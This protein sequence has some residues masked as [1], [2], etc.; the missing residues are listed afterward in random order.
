MLL[1][2]AIHSEI[3]S[4]TAAFGREFPTKLRDMYGFAIRPHHLQR[5]RKYAFIYKEEETERS[6]RWELFLRTYGKENA[7]ESSALSTPEDGV[8]N[9]S[10]DKLDSDNS[11]GQDR[12]SSD[13]SV[14]IEH[15][16]GADKLLHVKIREIQI[17]GELRP[18]LKTLGQNFGKF[19]KRR[20]KRDSFAIDSSQDQAP[21]LDSPFPT[22]ASITATHAFTN[23][24]A[25]VQVNKDLLQEVGISDPDVSAA[26]E[27]NLKC[28]SR[29][30][31]V[32]ERAGARTEGN[33]ENGSNEGVNNFV[34]KQEDI[35]E[36]EEL[37]LLVRGGV[38][39]ALRGELWQVFVG[40]QAR[41]VEGHYN[42]LLSECG[43]TGLGVIEK[44]TNQIEKDLPR[45]FPGH[46]SLDEDGRNA[47]RRLLTAYARDN[48]DVGYCQ[49]MNFFAALLLLLMPEENAF[50]TL[51]GI[52]N[53]YFEGYYSE[54]MLEAQVDQLVFGDL[55]RENFPKLISH[56]EGLGVQVTWVSGT[57]FL[58]IFVNVLPW[59]SVL[60]VWD[61]LL[62]DGNR[63]M[64]FRTALALMDIHAPA[65]MA[66]RDAG[67]AIALLQSIA[68]STFDSS[69][70]VFTACMGFQIHEQKLHSLRLKHRPDVIASLEQR[71][72][73]LQLYRTSQKGM[74]RKISQNF[75]KVGPP[76]GMLKV[77]GDV[78]PLENKGETL[79]QLNNLETINGTVHVDVDG[80]SGVNEILPLNDAVNTSL[81][82]NVMEDDEESDLQ[83]QIIWL[84]TELC[85][86]L[87]EK[88]S[89]V[90]RA[91]E[92]ELALMEMVKED[93]R[94]L[95]SAQLEKLEIEIAALNQEVLDKEEQERAMLQVMLRMEQEQ[96]VTEDARRFAEEDS[97]LHRHAASLLQE[98]YVKAMEEL[99]SME[100]RAVMAESILE[101]TLQYQALDNGA[102]N[103]P[104]QISSSI[105][106]EESKRRSW[107][108]G[109]SARN[110]QPAPKSK[111]DS[112]SSQGTGNGARD[113]KLIDKGSFQGLSEES[114][115]T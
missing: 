89:A 73:E 90:I 55:V 25:D 105:R 38:P 15:A 79:G 95:L 47:L 23:S 6:E 44:W 56:L 27:E 10:S 13:A 60:R 43:L 96:K 52:I 88:N 26:L 59:E 71:S 97:A 37:R 69:Q 80:I 48:P 83:E 22:N 98:K 77:E 107:S 17:W 4:P 18:S 61:V 109:S 1:D 50:W 5:Y 82:I 3:S 101:A 41:R 63:S 113:P 110:T 46:P 115:I 85:R 31:E 40:T 39:M 58:S 99:A 53:D 51:T 36:D 2:S 9:K 92:L 86:A 67:D 72:L 74:R 32:H 65:L 14:E 54:K 91:E 12:A 16:A 108:F 7:A 104:R 103:I 28:P 62:F 30:E 100:K 94:R 33:A 19:L 45:T 87:E 49:A 34:E 64:L 70:L 111:S 112:A 68:G 93:N 75:F 21:T 81:Q 42:R 114:K 29:S 8:S 76:G 66:A 35:W 11:L 57:W 78:M 24:L 106:G 84:K 102:Q 20:K